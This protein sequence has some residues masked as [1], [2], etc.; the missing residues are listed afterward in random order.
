M[1]GRVKALFWLAAIFISL[2]A[3]GVPSYSIIGLGDL[4]SGYSYAYGINASGQV[5]GMSP[6]ASS[7]N[8]AF[9]WSTGSITDL[10][11]LNADGSGAGA[12]YGINDSGQV[13]GFAN[14]AGAGHAF[15]WNSGQMTD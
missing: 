10:G 5:V 2:P 8:R 14:K 1:R 13:V 3:L 4:G 7:V 9:L 12:A 11:T 6:N 15:I